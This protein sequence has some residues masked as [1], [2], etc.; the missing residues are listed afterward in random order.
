M[1]RRG[2]HLVEYIDDILIM[3]TTP[4][5]SVS[6]NSVQSW[7][8]NQLGKNINS[9]SSNGI[10]W[11]S[12]KLHNSIPI[13]TSKKLDT[14][15]KECCHFLNKETVSGWDLTHLIGLLTSV[16]VAVEVGPLHYRALQRMKHK[17]FYLRWIL[18]NTAPLDQQ[19]KQDLLFWIKH[20]QRM[21]RRSLNF[22]FAQVAISTDVS[23]SG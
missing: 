10:P 5:S 1:R 14:V 9:H 4:L 12:S 16:S 19:V 6:F 21:N 18:D 20:S 2:I 13:S 3:G 17:I 23:K 8:S 15:R 11:Y 22:P 7:F